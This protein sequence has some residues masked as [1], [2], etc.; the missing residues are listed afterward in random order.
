MILNTIREKEVAIKIRRGGKGYNYHKTGPGE[1]CG[2]N[3]CCG[4]KTICF[5]SGSD[6]QKVSAPG[7]EPVPATALE[8]PVITDFILKSTFFMFLMK[9]N[10][11]NS[12]ARSYSI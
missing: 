11:P 6:F 2:N 8:V 1:W 5:R 12:H 10:R 3:Q 7:P 9:E 4:A